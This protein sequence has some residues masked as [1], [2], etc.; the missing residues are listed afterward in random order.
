[1]NLGAFVLL[2]FAFVA[3]AN[4]AYR[5]RCWWRDR[6][7][8]PS[9]RLPRPSLS[10]KAPGQHSPDLWDGKVSLDR[11]VSACTERHLPDPPCEVEG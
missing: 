4:L 11:A 10:T 5:V 1:M 2:F 6:Q 8:R 3:L 9:V 7:A